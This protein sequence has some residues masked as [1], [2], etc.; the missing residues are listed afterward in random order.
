MERL[1]YRDDNY[2][3]KY[4][5]VSI[6]FTN[7]AYERLSYREIDKEQIKKSIIKAFSSIHRLENNSDF[8]LY[9]NRFF[10][11]IPGKVFFNKNKT[12]ANILIK[13]V[14]SAPKAYYHN[15]EKLIFTY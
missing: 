8:K 5:D 11:I 2:K 4:V 15:N 13:T 1:Y 10:L 7:H 12:E 14:F 6:E 3:K 9:S